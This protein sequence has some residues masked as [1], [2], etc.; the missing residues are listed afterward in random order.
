MR[1]LVS[2]VNKLES[3]WQLENKPRPV[4]RVVISPVVGKLNLAT[5]TCRRTLSDTGG[6]LEIIQ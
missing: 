3:K 2:R 1:H 5:S 4:F 6:V